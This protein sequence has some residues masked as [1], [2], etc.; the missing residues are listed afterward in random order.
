MRKEEIH[1]S[2]FQQLH[3][4]DHITFPKIDH[5]VE[6]VY[7]FTSILVESADSLA[8]YLLH[9]GIQT[10][11]FFYPLHLQP[12][13]ATFTL[14]R[15]SYPMTEQLYKTGLSLPSSFNLQEGDLQYIIQSIKE[16][17]E[18]L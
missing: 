9:K 12:C 10:R 1:K 2:Y 11:R 6:P 15:S 16:Y 7:W 13:Y 5:G 17:F 8:D 3:L 14:D 4:I 18:A